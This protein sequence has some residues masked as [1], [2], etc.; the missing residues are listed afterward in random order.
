MA[1]Y[2]KVTNNAAVGATANT[3][4]SLTSIT[5]RSDARKTLGMWVEAAPVT[6]TAAEEVTGQLRY[7]SSDL[8]IGQQVAS[9]PPYVGGNPATN[10]GFSP[11]AAE[12]I[13]FVN[14]AKGKEVVDFAYS[15]NLPDPTAGCSVCVGL[16]YDAGAQSA[17]GSEAMKAWPEMAAIARG[18]QNVSLATI[19]TVAETAMGAMTVPAWAKEIVGFKVAMLPNLMTAGEEVVG[20]ARFRSTIPDFEPQ[21]WPFRAAIGAPLGTPVGYGACLQACPPMGT[22]FPLTG[23]SETI[24]PYIVLNVAIT[25]G[26]AAVATVYYR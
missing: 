6:A 25:T 19:T 9:C 22:M 17:L 10:I 15:T 23:Q 7:S 4:D 26:H 8:G 5:L 24:T 14:D 2:S 16:V 1:I 13:P 11:Q 21:E 20:F 12:F 18:A 3:F